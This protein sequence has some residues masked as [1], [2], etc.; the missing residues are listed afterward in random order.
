MGLLT[1]AHILKVSTVLHIS[2][3]ENKKIILNMHESMS[4]KLSVH[5][6]GFIR[7]LRT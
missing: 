5:T 3:S 1:S 4:P 7:L 2:F 6:H